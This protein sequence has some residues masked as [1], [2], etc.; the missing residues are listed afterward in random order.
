MIKNYNVN[1]IKQDLYETLLDKYIKFYD[2]LNNTEAYTNTIDILFTINATA[3]KSTSDLI[4]ITTFECLNIYSGNTNNTGNSDK[5]K[6]LKS[7]GSLEI[8]TL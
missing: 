5:I 3:L 1:K 2:V 8:P 6:S 7:T 4:K